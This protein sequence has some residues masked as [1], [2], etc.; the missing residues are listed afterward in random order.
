M[1]N[2]PTA[3]LDLAEAFLA[4]RAAQRDSA[5]QAW[6]SLITHG[7]ARSTIAFVERVTVDDYGAATLGTWG[8]Y[9][10]Q[11]TP[12]VNADR[13]TL[14]PDAR[15]TFALNEY[16]WVYPKG[17]A[18]GLAAL[19]WSPDVQGEPAGFL[20]RTGPQRRAGKRA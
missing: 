11:V 9:L 15:A 4:A 12:W 18:A 19:S 13:L 8:G 20:E 14:T 10:V 16:G 3:K 5:S 6:T 2:Q 1:T 17:G 7:P